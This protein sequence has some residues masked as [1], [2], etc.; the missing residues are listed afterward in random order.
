MHF[1]RSWAYECTVRFSLLRTNTRTKKRWCNRMSS[2]K[3]EILLEPFAIHSTKWWSNVV[4]EDFHS[5]HATTLKEPNEF[6]LPAG[7]VH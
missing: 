6:G 5:Y 3:H 7:W 1:A 4:V 2:G